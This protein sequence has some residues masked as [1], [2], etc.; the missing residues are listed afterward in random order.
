MTTAPV[1][2]DDDSG[3]DI[4][5]VKDTGSQKDLLNDSVGSLH[6]HP[7]DE[8]GAQRNRDEFIDPEDLHPGCHAGEFGDDIAHIGQKHA[9]HQI[10][11]DLGPEFFPDQIGEPFSRDNPHPGAHLL[12]HDQGDH[13]GDKGPDESEAVLGASQGIGGDPAG[14]IIDIGGDD[15]GAHEDEEEP[16]RPPQG[17]TRIEANFL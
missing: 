4:G 8:E 16:D 13:N 1:R 3:D 6:H 17:A 10:E 9:D 11:G 7:P 5:D 12:Y 2:L 14:I 15:A